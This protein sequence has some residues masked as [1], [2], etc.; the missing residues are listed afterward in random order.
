MHL[1]GFEV[2]HTKDGFRWQ[3]HE[4]PFL[5]LLKEELDA[6]PLQLLKQAEGYRA[7]QR[8]KDLR[9]GA[10]LATA[11][12]AETMNRELPE[13]LPGQLV[14]PPSEA[15]LP[16]TLPSIVTASR[17][18]IMVDLQG[19]T[20]EIDIELSADPAVGDWIELCEQNT[21][22][23]HGSGEPS[24][25]VGMRLSLTHPFMERFAGNDPGIIE[26]LLRV[27]AGIMLAEVVARNGGVKQAGTIRRNLNDLLRDA[28][29]KP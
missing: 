2:S 8:L 28:L 12:T 13:V 9:A 29:S 19:V 17:R 15:L 22:V 7:K 10:D 25:K 16:P 18:T 14:A 11:H 26:P 24:R 23:H 27:A 20:W 5:H 4:E 3:E 6:S 21:I 1:E